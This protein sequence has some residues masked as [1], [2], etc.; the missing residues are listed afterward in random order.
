MFIDGRYTQS[1]A[2]IEQG[3][4]RARALYRREIELFLLFLQARIQF[5]LGAYEECSL[6]LQSCL[7]LAT[8]YPMEGS[9][10]VLRAWLG[11][12]LLHQG[13]IR[14]GTRL[15]E[16][17]S[18][19]SREVLLFQAEGALFSG[20]LE[21]ASLFI[22]RGL[23]R[24]TSFRFPS[25]EGI[26]WHDGFCSIEGRCFRMSR[27]DAHLRR[28]LSGLRAYLQGLRGFAREGIAELHQLTRGEKAMDED[29]LVSWFNFLYQRILPETGADEMD[30]K[31]TVLSK[32]LK[33]LQARSSRIDAPSERSSYLWRNRWNRM[34]MEDARE[35]KL[36]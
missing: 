22:E 36:L 1:L 30:D 5:Q 20:S 3:I 27:G 11:R 34:I 2:A 4:G 15:L 10:H 23:A 29:P 17:L 28:T 18:E 19:Q 9:L 8:L 35:R 32:S 12:T 6:S 16:S 13:E 33:S 14:S 26:T 7:C 31:L 24:P 25:P 21:N